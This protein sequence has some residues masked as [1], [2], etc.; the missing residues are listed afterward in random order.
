MTAQRHRIRRQV[1][2]VTVP[3]GDR[4]VAWQLQ[5]ELARIQKSALEELLDRCLSEVGSPTRLHRIESLVVDLGPIKFGNLANLQDELVK[6]LGPALRE[7]LATQ[8]RE[9]DERAAGRGPDPESSAR[10]EL[11]AL[12][13]NSG[14]LPWWADSSRPGV[15]D[16]AVAFLLERA[17]TPLVGLVQSLLADERERRPSTRG[18]SQLLRLILACTDARLEGLLDLLISSAQPALAARL[19]TIERAQTLR[20]LLAAP[21]PLAAV[22]AAHFRSS[23]W[24]GALRAAASP[25][26]ISDGPMG[27]WRLALA[28]LALAA[29]LSYAPLL[30][31]LDRQ[32]EPLPAAPLHPI[33]RALCSELASYPVEIFAISGDQDE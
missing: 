17:A 19:G 3:G 25:E 16:E 1:L 14:N 22:T 26:A 8:I 12:F 20:L 6:K 33:V 9:D 18:P 4:S 10:L 29:N 24:M 28:Q 13:L 5:T 27:F 7:A 21:P 32:L 11:L 15:V 30:K 2:E 31:A 23:V